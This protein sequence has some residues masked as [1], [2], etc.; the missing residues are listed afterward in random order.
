MS[1]V[2][3]SDDTAFPLP[4][5]SSGHTHYISN[6]NGVTWFE[7][8]YPTLVVDGSPYYDILEYSSTHMGGRQVAMQPVVVTNRNGVTT[9]AENPEA[10]PS[11]NT[12]VT[13]VPFLVYRTFASAPQLEY[14]QWF[15]RGVGGNLV[16]IIGA[17]H[18]DRYY[19]VLRHYRPTSNDA[20]WAN[21]TQTEALFRIDTANPSYT[22]TM[23][24]QLG[25]PDVD[26]S[27]SPTPTLGCGLAVMGGRVYSCGT[28][29]AFPG[30]L[31]GNTGS[32]FLGLASVDVN[33]ITSGWDIDNVDVSLIPLRLWESGPAGTYHFRQ[34]NPTGCIAYA[35]GS[36]DRVW[37]TMGMPSVSNVA[38]T[39][40]MRLYQK[41]GNNGAIQFVRTAGAT[42]TSQF[43]LT[44]AG[45]SGQLLLRIW[46]TTTIA[47]TEYDRRTF[48]YTDDGGATWSNVE[49]IVLQGAF[50]SVEPIR[51]SDCAAGVVV[52]GKVL[53]TEPWYV[54]DNTSP[55]YGFWQ[56]NLVR[57][58]DIASATFSNCSINGIPFV[59]SFNRLQLGTVDAVTVTPN[60]TPCAA[61]VEIT[62]HSTSV[63]TDAYHEGLK[64]MYRNGV[65]YYPAVEANTHNY[66]PEIRAWNGPTDTLAW[67]F[68]E[69]V[70]GGTTYTFVQGNTEPFILDWTRDDSY[71]Y[72]LAQYNE[73][74]ASPF[75]V[76]K[77]P[78]WSN[79]AASLFGAPFQASG[80]I[81][82]G[83]QDVTPQCILYIAGTIYVGGADSTTNNP[84]ILSLPVSAGEGDA[85]SFTYTNFSQTGAV[86]TLAGR[87]E[88]NV[89]YASVFSSAGSYV[90]S[91][92]NFW[93]PCRNSGAREPICI[94]GMGDEG[95]I[96]E[97][98][99]P[100][101]FLY[102]D[103]RGLT[104]SP[105][106]SRTDNI[107]PYGGINWNGY[108][109]FQVHE[110]DS[111]E[112]LMGAL[113]ANTPAVGPVVFI[114]DINQVDP[115]K[116]MD[117]G[118]PWMGA[119][120]QRSALPG[121][122]AFLTLSGMAPS[123]VLRYVDNASY[124]TYLITNGETELVAQG[125][126]I[127]I[128]GTG[129]D[130]NGAS[131]T[132]DGR[133]LLDVTVVNSTLISC[134]H[135]AEGLRIGPLETVTGN[136]VIGT[137]ADFASR[138]LY[139]RNNDGAANSISVAWWPPS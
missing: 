39:W 128:Y 90:M 25:Y 94:Y 56:P 63:P 45:P 27:Y 103:D 75:V 91:G 110:L 51:T 106:C 13:G 112:M 54:G 66:T 12:A 99:T 70:I 69:V 19:F 134:K 52:D 53:I 71:A 36:G 55:A 17:G 83:A 43:D 30:Y 31:N 95:L 59:S 3:I 138:R 88:S 26:F 6:D 82:S 35:G 61:N 127:F 89:C 113:S 18:D 76:W 86:T 123:Y 132:I 109:L 4:N 22:R 62:T 111:D 122:G 34:Y 92:P 130:A 46:D 77:V 118:G 50:D 20:T 68:P 104:W 24:A 115:T 72:V 131:A 44:W 74:P 114:T 65:V 38:A 80:E 32:Y 96:A 49:T 139:V 135:P 85:W 100:H 5:G 67:A 47:N 33:G 98:G 87:P 129:F 29:Y 11:Y 124:L 101:L 107:R 2:I 117:W 23:L 41:V 78:L 10:L 105:L 1:L 120:D 125:G 58:F 60:T 37:F 7:A 57:L 79:G 97:L 14:V 81:V 133:E 119:S 48:A 93:N 42:F 116:R 126:P 108:V 102:T 84:V 16:D 28:D 121:N 136:G 8:P 40:P 9:T 73:G 64:P 15:P 137:T 21:G